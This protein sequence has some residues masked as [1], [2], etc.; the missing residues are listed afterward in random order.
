MTAGPAGPI[1]LVDIAMKAQPS[2]LHR[3]AHLPASRSPAPR[4]GT[5]SRLRSACNASVIVTFNEKD[6]P[7][8]VLAA[9][10]IEA[11]HPEPH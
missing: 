11:Q 6:F 2:S 10:G 8:Q 4:T 7:A 1:L 3:R 9:Y 5:C